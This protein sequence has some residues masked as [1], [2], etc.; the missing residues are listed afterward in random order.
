MAYS[1]EYLEEMLTRVK[2]HVSDEL[3][4][5]LRQAARSSAGGRARW[6]TPDMPSE[7]ER[8]ALATVAPA[9]MEALNTD[10]LQRCWMKL[11]QWYLNY[12]KMQQPTDDIVAAACVTRGQMRVR[13]MVMPQSELGLLA[14][15]MQT[16]MN[17][18]AAPP[19]PSLTAELPENDDVME[20]E[21]VPE[22]GPVDALY[23]FV[24]GLP[25]AQD[26]AR[27]EPLC[28]PDGAMLYQSYLAPL[29]LRRADI[30][31]GTTSNR[32]L[33][34]RLSHGRHVVVAL[35]Q[36]ARTTL[37]SC[38]D[39]ALPH[40]SAVR[41]YGDRGEI[42][43]KLRQIKA[44]ARVKSDVRRANET[45]T[46]ATS[47]DATPRPVELSSSDSTTASLINKQ[48]AP[49]KHTADAIRS[50]TLGQVAHV[51]QL[52]GAAEQQSSSVK[53]FKT[54]EE[55]RIVY[56][57]VLDPYQID[58]HGDYI[59]P[60]EIQTTA[61]DWVIN[62]RTIGLNHAGPAD[63]VMVE[64]WVEQY[65]SRDDYLAAQAGMAHNAYERPFGTDLVHSGA[66]ILATKLS[67]SL[68]ELFKAGELNAFSIGGYAVRDPLTPSTMPPVKFIRA[69]G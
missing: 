39:I 41:K 11:E 61:H 12:V 60:K 37:G 2:P 10:E 64:S 5:T 55:A 26:K 58:A 15:Q 32:R 8:M 31:I 35:G 19:A 56:G 30:L 16:E 24:G 28:G 36:L 48:G 51:G 50:V 53:I 40:P 13:D 20:P 17:T 44:A 46:L 66:W 33:L 54:D 67:P 23:A 22:I 63:A 1:R 57:V 21:E 27:G 43:R 38:C 18:E 6:R 68:W 14:D 34:K 42:A 49:S 4:A 47:L 25:S 9:S 62:S 59:S 3:Y 45:Q 7:M 52:A 65:P 29:G 69:L